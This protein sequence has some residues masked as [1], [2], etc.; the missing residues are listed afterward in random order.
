MAEHMS[1]CDAMTEMVSSPWLRLSLTVNLAITIVSFPVLLGALYY[2]NTQRLF[3]RNTRIQVQVHIFGLLIHSTG[4]SA[5]HL[6]DLINYLSNTGCDALPNFYRCLITR[7]IYNF[8]LALAAMCSASL[9]IERFFALLYSSTYEMC[10]KT[11]GVLLGFV[12]LVLA[13]AFLFKLYLNAPFSPDP[14]HVLYYC[15]T[16]ASGYGSV[17]TIN[18]PLYAVVLGQCVCRFVFW[19]LEVET[20]K[21]RSTQKFHTLSTR[22][23]LEQG[24]RSIQALNMFINVNFIVFTVLSFIETILHFN[25]SRMQRPTYFALVEVIHFLPT[26]GIILSMYIYYSLKKLDKKMKTSLAQSIHVDPNV[27]HI[28]FRRQIG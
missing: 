1:D 10:S 24:I 19:Y 17:W 9:V 7:G 8:G 26:Y 4:R 18:A 15:Q 14:D 2:I 25:I 11:F 3:H 22:Y 13:F 21:T 23:T 12:Q 27:Y 20:K 28:E 16:L 6:L 5:L